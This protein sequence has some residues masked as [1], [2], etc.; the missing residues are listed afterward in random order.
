MRAGI[1]A[2]FRCRQAS[3]STQQIEARSGKASRWT[4]EC[5]QN[6]QGRRVM[7]SGS[8]GRRT[9]S[10]A[11]RARGESQS[12][13]NEVRRFHPSTGQKREASIKGP[14]APQEHSSQMVFSPPLTKDLLLGEGCPQ[15]GQGRGGGEDCSTMKRLGWGGI[16]PRPSGSRE[17]AGWRRRE[18][19]GKHCEKLPRPSGSGGE[20]GARSPAATRGA[21]RKG[22]LHAGPSATTSGGLRQ[23][24]AIRLARD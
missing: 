15:K 13:G 6:G 16:W 10:G 14:W 20:E 9:S 5:P 12:W 4:G 22:G 19:K 11:R 23:A 1:W 7:S 24:T 2:S 17:E 18:R 21:K 8:P 3:H